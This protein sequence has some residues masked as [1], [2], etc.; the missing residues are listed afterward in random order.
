MNVGLIVMSLLGA[1]LLGLVTLVAAPVLTKNLIFMA[2]LPVAAGFFLMM[3]LN[4]NTMFIFIISTRSFLDPFLSKTKIGGGGG[5]GGI[6]NVFVIVMV[7][8][9][10]LRKPK[11][12]QGHRNLIPWIAF[13]SISAVTVLF[14]PEP[15]AAFKLLLNLMTYAMIFIAP[16]FLIQNQ[17]D[18]KF[19]IKLLFISSFIPIAVA[20]LGVVVKLPI[21]YSFHR[22]QGTFTHSNILAF[23][24]VLMTTITF[25][26]LKTRILRLSPMQRILCWCYFLDILGIL[27][28]TQTRSAWMSF[29]ASFLI[30]S[31]IRERKMLLIFL[32]GG[33]LMLALPPV[34][35]RLKDLQSGTGVTTHD[36][37]NS[38]AW[39]MKLWESALPSIRDRIFTGHGLGSFEVLSPTFFKLEKKGAPAHNVYVELIFETGIFGVLSYIGIFVSLL[40]TF[41]RRYRHSVGDMSKESVLLFSYLI[42]YMMVCTSDN[43]LYYLAFNWYLWFFVGVI[44]YAGM[45]PQAEE[46][47]ATVVKEKTMDE[48]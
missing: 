12:L 26:I 23:Y 19:W 18:K 6:L 40:K 20:N 24:C 37:L 42:G 21:L 33:I 9:M 36:K 47:E 10:I 3:V 32:F 29:A 13:L 17:E 15:P 11:A 1:V 43:A 22:L 27:V 5:I 35:N 30:Y 45:L 34:Q 31:L 44:I 38:M 7:A 25:Y 48:S 39:R 28:I 4:F 16:C 46:A 8:L 14:S 2:M 41:Y